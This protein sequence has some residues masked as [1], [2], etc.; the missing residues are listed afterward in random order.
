MERTREGAGVPKALWVSVLSPGPHKP[1]LG[2][3]VITTLYASPLPCTM[4]SRTLTV[5]RQDIPIPDSM[6]EAQRV[7]VG[8]EEQKYPVGWEMQLLVALPSSRKAS[9]ICW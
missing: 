1:F 2:P 3:K 8:E 5:C 6:G 4:K 9:C 7:V